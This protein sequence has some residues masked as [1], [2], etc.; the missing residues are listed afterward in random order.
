[1]SDVLSVIASTRRRGAETFAVDLAEAIDGRWKTTLLAASDGGN[2]TSQR[3]PDTGFSFRNARHLSATMA[4]YDVAIA[5][6]SV[7][8]PLFAATTSKTPWV[9]RSIGDPSYWLNTRAR[10]L[11]ARAAMAR[12]A[13]VTVLFEAA[14]QFLTNVVGVN[15]TKI[16]VIPNGI[17]N[18]RMQQVDYISRGAARKQ[19]DL[20]PALKTVAFIGSLTSEKDPLSAIRAVAMLDNVLLLVAGEGPM[21]DEMEVLA[22]Q[23][24]VA[25]KFLGSTNDVQA[26][27]HASDVL[28]LTSRTE[29]LPGV[30]IEAGFVGI[31]T[32]STNV[33]GASEIIVDQETGWLVAC[34]EIDSLSRAVRKALEASPSI[35]ANAHQHCVTRFEIASIA[36]QWAHLLGELS[37]TDGNI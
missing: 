5:H 36:D 37:N 35:G 2:I 34:D 1:M 33:G 12:A 29:G 18:A 25:V 11:K 9:Y 15:E 22:S 3:L 7:T 26:V 21:R 16:S 23:L 13:H 4:E 19:F 17:P 6:G 14:G 24:Q 10:R 20:H 27:L 30:L 8:L 32:V 28:I 31:P